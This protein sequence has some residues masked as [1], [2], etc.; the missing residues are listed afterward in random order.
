MDA[1][2]QI[3]LPPVSSLSSST[4]SFLNSEQDLSR[5]RSYIDELQSQCFDLDRTLIDLN[6][7]LHSTLLSYAS[8]SDGIHLLFDDATSKLTDLRSFTCPPPLSSS[9]SPSDGQGRKEGILGEALPALAKEVARVETVRVYAET[10]L[11]L[12]TLV[13]DIE[14]AVSS[15]MNRKL[16]KHSSTQS[17]EEMRLLAIERLGHSEDVL[18]SVTETHPQWTS[19]VSAVDHRID[20]AL[21]TLRPQAIADHRS[22]LGS[23]G[24]PPPLS[25]LTSSNLDSGKSAEVSNPLF[26]MQGLLKQQYCE[27]FLALCHLQELQ[28]RRKSRQLE[29]HNRK[30]ALQQPLWAIEELVN[31]I[32]IACQRHFSK[33]IDKP[34]FVFALVYK[35]TRDYVDTMDELL[36]PLVDEARLVGYSCREEWISAMVTSLITYLAKEIFP[37]YVAELDGES[38]SGVQSK[39][40]GNLQKISSLSVFCDQPDWLDIWAEIELNDT[41]E[42]LKPEVDD[43]RNWTAK[44]EGALL[45]GF[46]SYKSPAVSSAFVR[47]L[48]LVVDRC[49]SLPNTFL[50]SRFLK[51][52]GGSITQRYLDCLLLRCQE[53]EGLTALTDDNGLIKVAN[54]VNA[55]H[56]F[57]SVLKEW[58]EDTFFLELGF[59]HSKQLGIGINDNSG[60]AGRIDG[61]VGCVFDE[62]IKKLE[63]FRK[64][65]VERISVAV[66]R[67]FDA[68]CREY[69]KNRRQWQEKGEESWTI[70]KNLVGALDYLQ[71]KMAVA[72]ENLNRIDFVG[73]WRSLAAGVDHLLFNGLLMSMVKFHDAGVER[74]NC[75]MEI[76]FGVFRA[77]CLRPEAFFPKTSDG[78]KLLTMR[79]EQLR[80]TISGGGKRMKENGIIHLN[81]AEAEK[82]QNKRVFMS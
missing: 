56:Y 43:E 32:S 68:R 45:S 39:D 82:I 15:T 74:L 42:K 38:V 76:L 71:G 22:L 58:C 26:T 69:M 65:W 81:V 55:A 51:M 8:F 78:L 63:N 60:L 73:A 7:R 34:E 1:S 5:A 24:W 57:E 50:R 44:I 54:S 36:Q 29:G 17:V 61:P 67:G 2:I 46:E 59:D 4:L 35:I 30:V 9:L 77:W 23:L 66:L 19:L 80:D 47:R 52:A 28:W 27:N 64:E 3:T 21:A 40:D 6:S 14:D 12:D 79:E 37:K 33:W 20:R 70:S 48:L 72:E 11:K 75:D 16:R 10:A 53:A 18:I 41:L 13:G 62:E 31:P 25:T 49:R